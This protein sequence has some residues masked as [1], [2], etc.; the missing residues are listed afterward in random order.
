MSRVRTKRTAP[1]RAARGR[2]TR[3]A[4]LLGAGAAGRGRPGMGKPQPKQ[5]A[6]HRPAAGVAGRIPCG[7][8]QLHRAAGDGLYLGGHVPG[9]G[10]RH[11]GPLRRP[12]PQY[13]HRAGA[14]LRGRAVPQRPVPLEPP[15]HRRTGAG[16]RFDPLGYPDR[17]G[18]Q[19]RAVPGRLDQPLPAAGFG[20]PAQPSCAPPAWPAPTP[21]GW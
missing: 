9:V 12:G 20:Q 10:G 16:P 4:F 14:A 15:V 21:N 3:R 7:V 8:D 19:P 13:R 1:R 17:G 5:S 6:A 2:L 18:P 11:D